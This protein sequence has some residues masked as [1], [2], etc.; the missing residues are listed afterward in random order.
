MELSNV[1]TKITTGNPYWSEVKDLFSTRSSNYTKAHYQWLIKHAEVREK[2][3]RTYAYAIAEPASVAFVARHCG[4]RAIE[5]GA[6]TGYWAWQLSQHGIDIL[7]YDVAPPDKIPND[8]FAP[9]MEKPSTTLIK[10]W[11]TV[12]Q[13]GPEVLA[14]H[15]DRTLFLCW[16]PYASDFAYQC[17]S[18]YQGQRLVFIG[19]GDGG[20]TGDDDFFNLLEKQWK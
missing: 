13:G 11:H 15:A 1:S 14:E 2:C 8:F 7:A 10:T 17:L 20:C 19:E 6:G 9:R 3:C 18:V 12:Q 4:P 5:I 16:P